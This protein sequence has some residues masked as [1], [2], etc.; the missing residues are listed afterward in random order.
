[1]SWNG[2]KNVQQPIARVVNNR[3]EWFSLL[4]H[5][6]SPQN[7]EPLPF[8]IG[9]MEAQMDRKTIFIIEFYGPAFGQG[10]KL[11]LA[12]MWKPSPFSQMRV[13]KPGGKNQ[14]ET[15]EIPD[16]CTCMTMCPIDPLDEWYCWLVGRLWCDLERTVCYRVVLEVTQCSLLN[17]CMAPVTLANNKSVSSV[18]ELSGWTWTL[19]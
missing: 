19:I 14:K 15:D 8:H 6:S 18:P 5:G 12:V 13:E 4:P 10:R 9:K 7:G 11:Y 16:T 2:W 3:F 17:A 1:M